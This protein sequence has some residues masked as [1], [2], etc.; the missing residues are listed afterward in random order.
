MYVFVDDGYPESCDF[1]NN[2]VW[3]DL[4]DPA[5]GQSARREFIRLPLPPAAAPHPAAP[6]TAEVV[7]LED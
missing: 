7:T 2:Y 3:R 1:E 4:S 6:R 5:P